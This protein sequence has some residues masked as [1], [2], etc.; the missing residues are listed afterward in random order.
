MHARVSTEV[1]AERAAVGAN[2]A[3][4][5]EK[6]LA[7][8]LISAG[9]SAIDQDTRVRPRSPW[10]PCVAEDLSHRPRCDA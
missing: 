4:P 2:A 10:H 3:L 8:R 6:P 7:S 9:Q 5:S 1:S